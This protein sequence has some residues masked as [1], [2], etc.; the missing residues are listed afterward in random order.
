MR[1]CYRAKPMLVIWWV[2]RFLEDFLVEET[3]RGLRLVGDG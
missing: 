3:E 2:L 1:A